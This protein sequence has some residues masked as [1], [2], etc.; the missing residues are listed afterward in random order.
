G[1]DLDCSVGFFPPYGT[2]PATTGLPA[3]Q[4]QGLAPEQDW[5]VA[6]VRAFTIRMQTGE[7]DD[8]VAYAGS[9]YTAADAS[10][11][12]GANSHLATAHQMS[13]EAPVLLQNNGV[14]PLSVTSGEKTVVLG[15]YSTHVVHGGYSPGQPSIPMVSAADAISA[16]VTSQ[17][18]TTV[19]NDQAISSAVGAK[20]GPVGGFFTVAGADFITTD[21]T[22]P[23]SVNANTDL[24]DLSGWE[25]K[26]SFSGDPTFTDTGSLDGAFTVPSA[27]IPADATVINLNVS[28]SDIVDA[29]SGCLASSTQACPTYGHFD[30]TIGAE[31]NVYP[32]EYR[33]V[34]DPYTSAEAPSY[35]P[36]AI[37]LTDFPAYTPGTPTDIVFTF[38]IG[39]GG[40]GAPGINLDSAQLQE[41]ADAENVIVYLGTRESDSNEEQDR[42]SVA[43]PRWQAD[44][45]ALVGGLNPNTVVYIQAVGQV[46]VSAF[47]DKVAA[48]I[49]TSYN[50]QYQGQAAA[51]LLFG[52]TVT[53]ED[54]S[55]VQANPS[56]KLTYT[57]YSDVDAQLGKTADGASMDYRLSTA[58]GSSCGR[59][60]WYYQNTCGEPDYAF[61]HGLSYSTFAYSDLTVSQTAATPDDVVTVS[62][63]VTNTGTLPGREIV[64][65]YAISPQADGVDRPYK[66]LKGFAKT[67]PIEPNGF[68]TVEIDLPVADLWFW[69]EATQ[70]QVYDQGT[71]TLEVGA[72]SADTGALTAALALSGDGHHG[73]GVVRAIPDGVVLNLTTPNSVITS[74]TSVTRNDQSFYDLADVSV[75]Y[76]SSDPSVA[77]VDAN[78]VVRAVGVGVALITA[79]ATADGETDQD[80]FPVVVADG[81]PSGEAE[82]AFDYQIDFGDPEPTVEEARLGVQL[83]AKAVGAEGATYSYLIAPMDLNE[84]GATVTPEGVLTATRA[85]LVEVTVIAT[86][87]DV[88]ISRSVVIRVGLSEDQGPVEEPTGGTTDPSEEPTG[89]PSDGTSASPTAPGDKLP[90]TGSNTGPSLLVVA[91]ALAAFG[92]LAIRRS[93]LLRGRDSV[94]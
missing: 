64:Q 70:Q 80:T 89:G 61:G 37:P 21:G 29:P 53:L 91:L 87:G 6:L 55:T 50:G 13:L 9:D 74:L 7:F 39:S 38:A 72:S 48:I 66:Q 92:G 44:L 84:V 15:Y 77:S 58:E 18:G 93:R 52:Q 46:D 41:I 85:G 24:T 78:G 42:A 83:T 32:L 36:L 3:A 12:I 65:L 71:W 31:T 25:I 27:A 28:G 43:L 67:Q 57:Y 47:K 33:L 5:D 73:I 2:Y 49:W 68:E 94:L 20:P 51:E 90:V 81:Q 30:V 4:A 40:A 54:G 69:D 19:V 17:S 79:T 62:V 34:V 82:T 26:A 45:A 8:N 23:L 22:P 75:D 35:I 1:T 14:L 88:S 56:G 76:A 59:T 63:K 60:Y 86:V 16:Y 10:K 11:G